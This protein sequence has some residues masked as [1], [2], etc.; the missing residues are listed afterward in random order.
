MFL[1]DLGYCTNM[2]PPHVNVYINRLMYVL[3]IYIIFK[4]VTEH[5]FKWP[6]IDIADNW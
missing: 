3:I 4:N 2:A 6:Y 5:K 1:S